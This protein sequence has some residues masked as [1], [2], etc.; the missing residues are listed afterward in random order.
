MLINRIVKNNKQ[1]HNVNSVVAVRCPVCHKGRLMRLDIPNH[2][3][4]IYF[5]LICLAFQMARFCL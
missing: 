4:C 2:L 1:I 3:R 5:A